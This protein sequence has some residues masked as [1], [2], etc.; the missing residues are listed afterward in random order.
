MNTNERGQ[1]VGDRADWTVD[2]V[3][4]IISGLLCRRVVRFALFVFVVLWIW[5]S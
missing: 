5:V 4:G 2:H 1:V 3:A